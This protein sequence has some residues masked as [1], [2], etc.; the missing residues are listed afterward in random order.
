MVNSQELIESYQLTHWLIHKYAEGLTH[1]ESVLQ[2]PFPANCFNW[3]VGHIVEH[4]DKVLVLLAES[5]QLTKTE[6]A[7]YTSDSLPITSSDMAVPFSELMDAFDETQERIIAILSEIPEARLADIYDEEQ[8]LTVSQRIASLHWHE[9]YH[10]GQLEILRA[11]A[12]KK[13]NQMN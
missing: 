11:L 6:T 1:E 10:T 13:D 9:T 12:G 7:I 5:P 8:G 3:V 2:L 4:R